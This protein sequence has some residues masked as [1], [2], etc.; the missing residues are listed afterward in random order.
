MARTPLASRLQSLA[1]E[2]HMTRRQFVGAAG[3]AT[4]AAASW[5]PRARAAAAPKIVIVGGEHT[6]LDFQGYLN[7]AV[8]TG[9]RAA[10][11]VLAAI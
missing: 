2:A 1:A 5:T 9:E 7:G 8:F 6:T 10:S 3:A 11:E 4:F